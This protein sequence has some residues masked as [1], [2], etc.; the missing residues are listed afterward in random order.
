MIIFADTFNR[1]HKKQ[2]ALSVTK[3]DAN[4]VDKTPNAEICSLPI[5]LFR[6]D[7]AS[8]NNRYRDGIVVAIPKVYDAIIFG[9]PV[10]S[11]ILEELVIVGNQWSSGEVVRS[12]WST[13]LDRSCYPTPQKSGQR[14]AKRQAGCLF[15][16]NIRISEKVLTRQTKW[17]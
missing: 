9:S 6:S 12:R 10:C 4:T 3:I 1:L 2:K 17:Q 16:P 13:F 7:R 11:E 14:K 5:T 15:Q 8:D